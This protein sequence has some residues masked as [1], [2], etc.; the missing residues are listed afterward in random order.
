MTVCPQAD[1]TARRGGEVYYEKQTQIRANARLIASAPDL[2]E[3]CKKT[4]K[5]FSNLPK[6]TGEKDELLTLSA[7]E[8]AISKAEGRDGE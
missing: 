1:I 8:Q 3:A 4:L 2:L 6:L 5:Y 7:I